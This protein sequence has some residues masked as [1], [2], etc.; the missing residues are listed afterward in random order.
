MDSENKW[1]SSMGTVPRVTV[2]VKHVSLQA[3]FSEKVSNVCLLICYMYC[4]YNEWAVRESEKGPDSTYCAFIM[5]RLV[6]EK[7]HNDIR[8]N[9][10]DLSDFINN[11]SSFPDHSHLSSADV[12][13]KKDIITALSLGAKKHAPK[14]Q[15]FAK[16]LSINVNVLGLHISVICLHRALTYYLTN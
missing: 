15:G 11:Y 3:I 6:T 2:W 12:V 8:I 14:I 16:S 10:K 7:Q 9:D 1:V 5:L 13:G 4:I